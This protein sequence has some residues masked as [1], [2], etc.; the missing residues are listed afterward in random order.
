MPTTSVQG[1]TVEDKRALFCV[2]YFASNIHMRDRHSILNQYFALVDR[3]SR[4]LAAPQAMLSTLK[5][6]PLYLRVSIT[7][8]LVRRCILK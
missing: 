6:D 3:P 4:T 8:S 7:L 1:W 2:D 5:K